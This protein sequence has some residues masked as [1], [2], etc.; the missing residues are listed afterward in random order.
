MAKTYV[1][2]L[3]VLVNTICRYITRYQATIRANLNGSALIAFEAFVI[4]C[5]NLNVA[6]GEPP[7]NP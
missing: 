2:T 6:L 7:I 4:A 1:P 3:Y 5:D